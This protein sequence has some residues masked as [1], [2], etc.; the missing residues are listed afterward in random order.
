MFLQQYFTQ[1]KANFK[2]EY[3]KGNR[4]FWRLKYHLQGNIIQTHLN[5]LFIMLSILFDLHI[6][7]A[8]EFG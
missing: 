3:L 4:K 1:N 7:F 2:R 5:P 8:N 6:F